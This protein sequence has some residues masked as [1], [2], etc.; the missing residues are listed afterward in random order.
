MYITLP[1]GSLFYRVIDPSL[2]WY[3]ILAGKGAFHGAQWGGR[4]NASAQKTVYASTDPLVAITEYAFYEALKWQKKIAQTLLVNQ[5]IAVNSWDLEFEF[6]DQATMAPVAVN[7]F[8]VAWHWPRFRLQP[9]G[10]SGTIPAFA[11]RPQAVP[12]PPN[13]WHTIAVN[14]T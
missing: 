7:T 10:G 4:Y 9:R 2:T 6:L 13:Q 14:F 12:Y 5:R 1:A 3:D 11:Q 8:K